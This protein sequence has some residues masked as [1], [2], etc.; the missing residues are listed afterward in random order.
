MNQV[1][2]AAG[3][4]IAADAGAAVAARGGN[5]VDAAIAAMVVSV[6]TDTGIMSPGCGAFVTI[7][8][9]GGDPVVIDGYAEM[10]GRGCGEQHFAEATHE[11]VFDYGGDTHQLVGYGTIAT[12]GGFA[13][14]ASASAQFGRL[15]WACLFEPA[16]EQ[17]ERG[18]PLTGGAAEYLSYTHE[19][20]YS[21][22]PDSYRILHHADGSPLGEGDIVRVPCLADSL[23]AIA[24]D[25]S[26]LY[27]GELGQRIADG[28][29]ARGGLLGIEDLQAYQAAVRV[30]VRARIGD[31]EVATNPPPAVGGSCLAGMLLLLERM[32]PGADLCA[33]V[34]NMVTAQRAILGYRARRL[35]G[36]RQ[37]L[38]R[39][40]ERMLELADLGDHGLLSAPSTSHV[41][42]VD[43]DGLACAITASAGYGSGV[44][45]EGTGFW[46]NNSLGEIDLLTRGVS[47]LAP[48]TRLASNM[49]P[50]IAR[51]RSDGAVLALGSPGASRITTAI[52]QVLVNFAGQQMDLADAVMHPRLHVELA[53]NPG[54]IAFEPGLPVVPMLDLEPRPFNG[55]SMYFGGVQAVHWSPAQ[56]LH[57]IADAR[58]GGSVASAA[59]KPQQ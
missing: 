31:W 25:V 44:M 55:P 23:R 27:G 36:A 11:V 49:A 45:I 59:G 2:I 37:A 57:G 47:G 6:C 14:L 29:R 38:P 4:R 48:G 19:A 41:S 28:V 51:R 40:V 12:P 32:G 13:G 5:A 42:A 26:A 15:P 34:E 52:A 20:I 39:E 18:F 7:W 54:T 35:D 53:A 16:I 9:A 3:T 33:A 21:W 43:A 58:R 17:V 50:T 24:A 1:T 8:P 46:L 10:P 22:H 56:G 30:P